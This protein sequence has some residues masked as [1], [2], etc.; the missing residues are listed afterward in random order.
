[1]HPDKLA[2]LISSV[3][4]KMLKDAYPLAGSVVKIT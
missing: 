4:S 3:H 1:M 2:R